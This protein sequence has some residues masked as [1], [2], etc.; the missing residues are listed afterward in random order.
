MS[1]YINSRVRAF[2]MVELM[3]VICIVGILSVIS[4]S[5]YRDYVI[6]SAI[7][8]LI[9]LASEVKNAVEVAHNDG[10]IFGTSA[11]E[12]YVASSDTDRPYALLEMKRVNYGCINIGIDLDIIKL[13]STGGKELIITWCP[14]SDYGGLEWKCGY[15]AT[16]YSSYLKYLPAECQSS[17]T[18]IRDTSF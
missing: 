18:S 4:Y 6:R 17:S 9:P 10:T 12:V 16:S 13:D 7:S 15:D 11:A 3:S 2:S 1:N 5:S 14:T 8:A